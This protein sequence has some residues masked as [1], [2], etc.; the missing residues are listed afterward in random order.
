MFTAYVSVLS[1]LGPRCIMPLGEVRRDEPRLSGG[2]AGHSVC[3]CFFS[4]RK[5]TQH[6]YKNKTALGIS[7]L[8]CLRLC[9]T[10]W[11]GKGCFPVCQFH[12]L[13]SAGL[14]APSA[15][16]YTRHRHGGCLG[17]LALRVAEGETDPVLAI[18]SSLW[19]TKKSDQKVH[20]HGTHDT[21]DFFRIDGD[22]V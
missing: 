7:A 20:L 21:P 2:D 14:L 17:S 11:V 8:S 3:S 18:L 10:R 9:G 12:S 5:D 13:L 4:S 1:G 15:L 16:C 19:V 22:A 6:G